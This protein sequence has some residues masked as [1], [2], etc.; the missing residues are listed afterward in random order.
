M[1]EPMLLKVAL[2]TSLVG[3]ILL[4]LFS[5]RITVSESSIAKIDGTMQGEFVKIQGEVIKVTARDGFTVLEIEQPETISVIVFSNASIAK[6]QS[7]EILG[8]VSQYQGKEQIV[9]D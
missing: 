1:Q 8:K 2:A 3:L 5:S 6:G 7:L 4:F 9:A